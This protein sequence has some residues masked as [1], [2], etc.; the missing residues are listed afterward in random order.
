VLGPVDFSDEC[1]YGGVVMTRSPA[2]RRSVER[3]A[4]PRPGELVGRAIV[5]VVGVDRVG[6]I[7]GI[8]GVLA[9]AD[10][11]ILDISQSVMREFFT[12]I[13]MV[14]LAGCTVPFEQL[15]ATLAEKGQELSVEVR[16][17]RE[18]IFKAMHRL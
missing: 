13:M 8:S 15:G 14:D 10:V 12:M 17:Q 9:K 5:T 1:W 11:N 7:A 16:I 3:R 2:G 18:E 4:N 6:I